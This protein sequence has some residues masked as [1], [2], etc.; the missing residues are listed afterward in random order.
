M[1]EEMSK[2]E[3]VL[4]VLD[5]AGSP[6]AGKEEGTSAEAAGETPD[7]TEDVEE[8][9]AGEDSETG[10]LE[11]ELDLSELTEED[12]AVLEEFAETSFQERL[13]EVLPQIQSGW[14]K[15]NAALQRQLEEY[16]RQMDE[17]RR[18][19]R[20]AQVQGLPPEEREKLERIWEI[21][22]QKAALQQYH[23][24]LTNFYNELVIQTLLQEY[25]EYGVTEEMLREAGSLEEAEKLCL[26]VQNEFQSA[27]LEEL[28]NAIEEN[29]EGAKGTTK[30]AQAK[31]PPAGSVA[32]SEA[33]T[34]APTPASGGSKAEG[35][36]AL[37]ESFRSGWQTLRFGR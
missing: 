20:E 11:E 6:F 7:Q 36:D 15:R 35:I 14:D 5:E 4:V 16:Q 28:L 13:R 25:G 22:D 18:Q 10:D 21:E 31:K 19:L 12:L 37:A 33:G 17:I 8:P 23:Q 32:A 3:E 9:E 34:P 29:L 27:L 24:E 2:D 30:K 1:T 26:A